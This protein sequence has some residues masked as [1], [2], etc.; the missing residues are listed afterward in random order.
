MLYM[1]GLS[2]WD[3][4]HEHNT[5]YYYNSYRPPHN[6]HLSTRATFFCPQGGPLW[7]GLTIH[8]MYKILM[9]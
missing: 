8:E 7:K 4:E 9:Y 1:T 6:G 3:S 5:V 2:L